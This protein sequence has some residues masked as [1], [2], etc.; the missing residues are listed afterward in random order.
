MIRSLRFQSPL[1]R[2][3]LRYSSTSAS[4]PG[5]PPLFTKIKSDLKTAMRARDTVRL[6]VLRGIISEVNNAAKT[7]KAIHT[8]LLLLDLLRKR[9][10]NLEASGKEY[11]AAGREDLTTKAEAERKVV[12]EYAGQIETVS[13]E[14][15]R[16]AVE[17]VV[18]ELRAG[19]EKVVIGAILKTVLAAGGP[20]DGKPASKSTIAKIAG[21]VIKAQE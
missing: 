17:K 15:I 2:L 10:S 14:E 1:L 6:D 12:E 16:T 11:A 21:E 5:F 9:S 19:N 20:L 4:T 18:A 8:D 13:D 7:P 3:G